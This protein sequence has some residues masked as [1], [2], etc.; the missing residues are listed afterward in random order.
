M[1]HWGR[2]SFLCVLH[3]CKLQQIIEQLATIRRRCST[4]H[5]SP[6]QVLS[7]NQHI[8]LDTFAGPAY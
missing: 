5:I 8:M 6:I 2:L 3:K 4:L 7:D 1:P